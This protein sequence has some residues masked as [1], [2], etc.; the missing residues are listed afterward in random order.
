MGFATRTATGQAAPHTVVTTANF[1]WT[2]PL[3]GKREISITDLLSSSLGGSVS[4]AKVLTTN[5]PAANT[6][7]L[8]ALIDAKKTAGGVIVIPTGSYACNRLVI[9]GCTDLTIVGLSGSKLTTTESHVDTGTD[10]TDRW[11]LF[12]LKGTITRLSFVGLTLEGDN[13]GAKRQRGI[14]Y[15]HNS[16]PTI[17]GLNIENCRIVNFCVHTIIPKCTHV[18]VLNSWFDTAPTS[19][20]SSS[21]GNGLVIEP[22]GSTPTNIKVV[23]N[24]FINLRRH[25]L[26]LNQ[27]RNTVVTNNVFYRHRYEYSGVSTG[28]ATVALS[29]LHGCLFANNSLV[30]CA[31]AGIVVDA[32]STNSCTDVQVISNQI[33][34]MI[35]TSIY[36]GRTVNTAFCE[37]VTVCD[38]HIEPAAS[39]TSPDVQITDVKGLRFTHNRF[40]AEKNFSTTKTLIKL[41]EYATSYWDEVIIEENDARI[42]TASGSKYFIEISA[43]L[44]ASSGGR[45]VMNKNVAI[46]VTANYNYLATMTNNK[47]YCDELENVETIIS[48]G[49]TPNVAGR[50]HLALLYG[51]GTSIT[52]FTNGRDYQILNIISLNGN[53]TLTNNMYLAGAS[54]VTLTTNDTIT[55]QRMP[56]TPGSG[57]SSRWVEISRSVN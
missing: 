39:W 2:V 49:T 15:D 31:D 46:G 38:N 14:G 29:R 13:D 40:H 26:Y 24:T 51:S 47:V 52:D 48:S 10:N 32:D 55:L 53:A 57:A 16:V 19:T 43:A 1:N 9:D 41:S 54:N 45:I 3:S 37:A 35:G 25:S 42:S 8:Q 20:D 30:D 7:I 33:I 21:Q 27:T 44:S 36:V 23:G 34:G 18:Q 17:T 5:T 4:I 12:T 28:R 56:A 6:T 50:K 22:A 11:G